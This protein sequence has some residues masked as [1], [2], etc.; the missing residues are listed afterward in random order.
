MHLVAT[1]T[2]SVILEAGVAGAVGGAE[3]VA[4]EAHLVAHMYR[5]I[6]D[7]AQIQRLG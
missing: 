5:I 1:V 6:S 4:A 7:T 3:V 2:D